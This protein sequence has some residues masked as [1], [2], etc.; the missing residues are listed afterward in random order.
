MIRP[1]QKTNYKE[2][3]KIRANIEF[4][5]KNAIHVITVHAIE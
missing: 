3:F 4:N 5:D 2:V 1:C